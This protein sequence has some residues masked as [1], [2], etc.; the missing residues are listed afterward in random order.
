MKIQAKPNQQ[1]SIDIHTYKREKERRNSLVFPL[2]DSFLSKETKS[3]FNFSTH[4]VN[5][6][7][8][9]TY[10]ALFLLFFKQGW[11]WIKKA[12]IE[13]SP[14][15]TFQCVPFWGREWNG[16]LAKVGSGSWQRERTNQPNQSTTWPECTLP[17]N[18]PLFGSQPNPML[19]YAILTLQIHTYNWLKSTSCF[20][21]HWMVTILFIYS[22]CNEMSTYEHTRQAGAQ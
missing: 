3:L 10:L 4:S 15:S 11:N 22:H 18:F 20:A 12:W 2:T 13:S 9:C 21:L 19:C 14:Y 7:I 5:G 1:S 17:Q 16:I 6:G 8:G